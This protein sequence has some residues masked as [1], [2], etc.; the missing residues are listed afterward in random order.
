MASGAHFVYTW[1]LE[2]AGTMSLLAFFIGPLALCCSRMRSAAS[3]GRYLRG[4]SATLVRA[5]RRNAPTCH[6][7]A[8]A[9]EPR[10]QR[11]ATMERQARVAHAQS[12][13]EATAKHR[14]VS[15]LQ[16]KPHDITQQVCAIHPT[17]A[18]S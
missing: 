1:S 5:S 13:S 10:G 9:S 8:R 7:H 12:N 16:H 17:A 18:C 11:K 2:K 6:E 15:R 14:N 3:A 4:T